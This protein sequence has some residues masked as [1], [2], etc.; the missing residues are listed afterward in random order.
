M[1]NA[2]SSFAFYLTALKHKNF[3]F[4]ISTNNP[5]KIIHNHK[6]T[7]KD[8]QPSG[9]QEN[10][11]ILRFTSTL[12]IKYCEDL[13]Q[14]MFFNPSQKNALA[15]IED[16][17]EKFGLP[18]IYD[19]GDYLRVKVEKLD[20]V[21]TLFAMDN[22]ILTGVLVYSRITLERLTVI[23][24]AI[25]QDYSAQ[26]K[27]AHSMLMMRMLELLRNCARRIKGVETIRLMHRKNQFRD[28]TV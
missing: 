13:E 3:S 4:S 11:C 22:D 25:H 28:Y 27:H 17:L 23:H 19:D 2:G 21:Q 20:E 15:A 6:P 18:C 16:S 24:I 12:E 26:G 9:Q 7:T 5:E 10:S 14:L 8:Q 1:Q